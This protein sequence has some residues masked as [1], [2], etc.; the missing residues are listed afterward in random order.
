MEKGTV[1]WFNPDRNYGFIERESGSDVF[2]HGSEVEGTHI[3]R[4]GDRVTFE[5]E[6][7]D[8]GPKATKVMMDNTSDSVD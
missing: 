6:E 4:E 3:L 5:V 7:G 8:R 2:V 1:K